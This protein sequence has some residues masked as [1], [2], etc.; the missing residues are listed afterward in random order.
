MAMYFCVVPVN[1]L[2][3]FDSAEKKTQFLSLEMFQFISI[4]GF[5]L[6]IFFIFQL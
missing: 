3:L 6:V 2:H 1:R 4:T 5:I